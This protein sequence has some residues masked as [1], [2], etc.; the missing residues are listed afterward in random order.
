[1]QILMLLRILYEVSLNSYSDQKRR[2]LSKADLGLYT[3]Y[4][5]A[6]HRGQGG[7]LQEH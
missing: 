5:A 3:G 6:V 1:M 7:G 4:L 2:F